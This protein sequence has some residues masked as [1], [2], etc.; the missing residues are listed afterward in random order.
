MSLHA[1]TL[2]LVY[3]L[4]LPTDGRHS[5]HNL[6]LRKHKSDSIQ[7]HDRGRRSAVDLRL[8]PRGYW[9]R[10]THNN[11]YKNFI[12]KFIIYIHRAAIFYISILAAS[13]AIK[14]KAKHVCRVGTTLFLYVLRISFIIL[15]RI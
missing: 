3:V 11:V 1:L 9:D 5:K 14:T 13:T 8:R 6:L 10:L 15:H 4:S 12:F 2:S 7:T